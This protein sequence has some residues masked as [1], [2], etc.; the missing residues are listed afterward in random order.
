MPFPYTFPFDF[1]IPATHRRPYAL[2][3]RSSDGRLIRWLTQWTSA[4]VTEYW[5]APWELTL[6]VE[7][8]S[9]DYMHRIEAA[10]EIWV[11]EQ[12]GSVGAKFRILEREDKNE[13]GRIHTTI[14]AVTRLYQLTEET[15]GGYYKTA[16][17]WV[18]VN[19]L[20]GRQKNPDPLTI[21]DVDT[22]IISESVSVEVRDTPRNM[23]EILQ[24]ISASLS[25][26]N[27]FWVD[28]NGAIQWRDVSALSPSGIALRAGKNVNLLKRRV[29]YNNQVSRV[30]GYGAQKNGRHIGPY[31]I[32]NGINYWPC[33][34]YHDAGQEYLG[35]Y[36]AG[37]EYL[38]NLA[39]WDSETTDVQPG[40]VVRIGET[41][42][43]I[44]TV[45]RLYETETTITLD[46][47]LP[48][49]LT[50]VTGEPIVIYRDYVDSPIRNAVYEWAIVIDHTSIDPRGET[51]TLEIDQVLPEVAA[52]GG[53]N[54]GAWLW[55]LNEDRSGTIH[56][57]ESGTAYFNSETGAVDVSWNVAASGVRDTIFYL[58]FGYSTS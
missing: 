16:G 47:D 24:S 43:R 35:A 29:E 20:L 45:A 1:Y 8:D 11:I 46:G 56:F 2:Q 28:T 57:V 41:E 10:E 14:P 17:L 34:L 3:L 7:V 26:D 44:A 30:R 5:D 21:G 18:V 54:S 42:R 32:A 58:A 55:L 15:L 25:V 49:D 39:T 48:D 13:A 38:Q 51:Y 36:I 22:S 53:A 23:L 6:D 4:Y 27:R 37:N 40:D 9:T 12:D 31:D 33:Y 19:D 50:L 52:L